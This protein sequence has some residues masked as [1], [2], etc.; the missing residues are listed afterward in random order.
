MK[1]SDIIR[2]LKAVL[3]QFTDK[4][5]TNLSVSSLTRSGTTITAVTTT[6]HGL[7]TNDYANIVGAKSPTTINTLTQT[8]GVA[9]A[10]TATDHDLT[11]N[12]TEVHLG[13]EVFVEISGANE[14]DYNGTHKLLSVPNRTTFTYELVS[15]A[16]TPATGS[17]ILETYGLGYVGWHQITKVNDTTFTYQTTETPNSPAIGTIE[18]R[19]NVRVSGA[20]NLEE[21]EAAYTAQQVDELMGFVVVG[22]KTANKDR[23]VESDAVATM[24]RGEEY[25]QLVIQPFSVYCI[26]PATGSIA[27]RQ[28]RDD[29]DDLVVP[30]CKSL[31]RVPFSSGFTETAFS[32]TVFSG[33]RFATY[34]KAIYVH[35]YAFE[36][37]GWI[38][39]EDTVDPEYSVAFRDIELDFK[40]TLREEAGIIMT[41]NINLDEI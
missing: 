24:G 2:Q 20:L 16:P 3:P 18:A 35:E 31:L 39:Y 36:T 19:I 41:A 29:A 6:N 11:L 27:A 33:D 22:D 9:T 23:V 25:R 12:E 8:G 5:T 15:T 38:V 32:N 21:A 40:S 14:S 37:T 10:V 26:F 4:F 7:S 1:A 30:F 28:E 34:N 17:P 13:R